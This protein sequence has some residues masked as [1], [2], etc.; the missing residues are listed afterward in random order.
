MYSRKVIL[1]VALASSVLTLLVIAIL[2][3]NPLLST[4][5]TIPGEQVGPAA[6]EAQAETFSVKLIGAASYEIAEIFGRV[7]STA[8]GVVEARRVSSSIKPDN[9]QASYVNW[10]VQI[11]NTTPFQLETNMM[12]ALKPHGI[13]PQAASSRELSFIIDRELVRDNEMSGK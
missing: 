13:R 2:L 9:P 5:S 11:E 7:L 8:K 6:A 12:E 3:F 1:S 10:R 4:A